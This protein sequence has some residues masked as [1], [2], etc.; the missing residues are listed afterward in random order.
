M[1]IQKTIPSSNNTIQCS[2]VPNASAEDST[3]NLLLI[4]G[5]VDIATI[6]LNIECELSTRGGVI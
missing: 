3:L 6:V 4:L 1:T 5:G 2:R